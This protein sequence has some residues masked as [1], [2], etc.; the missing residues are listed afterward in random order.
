MMGAE[1]FLNDIL[2]VDCSVEPLS[3][4]KDCLIYASMRETVQSNR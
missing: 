4:K 2:V 3:G 1:I